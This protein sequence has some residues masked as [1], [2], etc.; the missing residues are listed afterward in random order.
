MDDKAGKPRTG[1][2]MPRSGIPSVFLVGF[3]GAGKTSVGRALGQRLGWDFVDLDEHIQHREGRSIEQIFEQSGESGFR[4]LEHSGLQDLVA[5]SNSSPRVVALGGGAYI[6]AKNAELL[7]S[8]G[9]TVIFLDAPVEEL[10]RRCQQ[11]QLIRPL[12][13][14]IEQFRDLYEKRRTA[15]AKADLLIDTNGKNIERVAEEIAERLGLS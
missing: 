15:Y 14:D 8:G 10:F 2:S 6:Q 13:R 1:S 4:D 12:R 9:M 11:E 3:M 7:A 5:E